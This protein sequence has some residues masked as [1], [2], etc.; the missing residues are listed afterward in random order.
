MQDVQIM[1]LCGHCGNKTVVRRQGAYCHE[2]HSP[3]EYTAEVTEWVLLE[4]QSCS[5][6]TIQ[7]NTLRAG[8]L[9]KEAPRTTAI[10]YPSFRSPLIGIPASI[11]KQYQAALKVRNVEPSACAVLAGRT[12]EAVCI[13]EKASGETLADQLTYLAGTGR[14]PDTLA[15]MTHQLRQIRN[16]E[17]MTQRNIPQKRTFLSLS[18][19]LRRFLSICMLLLRRLLR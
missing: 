8:L 14:I 12:L 13:Y 17:H 18:V 6:P 5:T 10:I 1:M 19:S 7:Q 2:D 3:N 11:E 16:M 4:C 9:M 15:H